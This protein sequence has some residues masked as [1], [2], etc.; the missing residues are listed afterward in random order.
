VR[1]RDDPGPVDGGTTIVLMDAIGISEYEIA[2]GASASF[3]ARVYADDR[4]SAAPYERGRA[5]LKGSR[6]SIRRPQG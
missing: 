4:S 2:G 1:L 3:F 5:G 6:G